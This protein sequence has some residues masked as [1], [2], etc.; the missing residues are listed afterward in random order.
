MCTS[1]L[2]AAKRNRLLVNEYK[3]S[4]LKPGLHVRSGVLHLNG[5]LESILSG[6][7]WDAAVQYTGDFGRALSFFYQNK[8]QHRIL[9]S[10]F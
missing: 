6:G 8:T 1:V 2:A 10:F 7:W 9:N 3:T 4:Y 5:K